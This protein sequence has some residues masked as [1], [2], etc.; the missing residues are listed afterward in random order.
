MQCGHCHCN[1]YSNVVLASDAVASMLYQM[2]R[3]Y[4]SFFTHLHSPTTHRYLHKKLVHCAEEVVQCSH[5][6]QKR[7]FVRRNVPHLRRITVTGM[8]ELEGLGG[9][10]GATSPPQILIDQLTLYQPGGIDYAHQIT[11]HPPDFQTFRHLLSCA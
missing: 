5:L 9:K 6:R 10:Q 11:T 7:L 3:T 4:K 8:A 2:R 1:M